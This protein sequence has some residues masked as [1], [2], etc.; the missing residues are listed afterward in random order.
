M[1]TK[2]QQ[3]I[4]LFYINHSKSTMEIVIKQITILFKEKGQWAESGRLEVEKKPED[5]V[6]RTSTVIVND[7]MR[8]MDV[9]YHAFFLSELDKWHMPKGNEGQCSEDRQELLPYSPARFRR[10]MVH[11][12]FC[13]CC[14]YFNLVMDILLFL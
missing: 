8:K 2:Y 1:S 5:S 4:K 14:C 10:V 9:F 3:N 11:L 13:C 6:G 7:C 12:L